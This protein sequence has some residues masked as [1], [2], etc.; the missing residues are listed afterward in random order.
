M[1]NNPVNRENGINS[2]FIY[3]G[4]MMF[5]TED[6][7]AVI[8][9]IHKTAVNPNQIS[10][11]F[12]NELANKMG[13]DLTSEQVVYISDNCQAYKTLERIFNQI[14]IKVMTKTEQ[15]NKIIADSLQTQLDRADQMWK[16]GQ[17]PAYIV[18]WLQGVIKATIV[19]LTPDIRLTR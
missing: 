1:K 19:E 6:M 11:N 3:K 15:L 10:P 2:S 4:K 13:R 5:L 18:G 12:V 17:S 7:R 9:K 16:E 14:K 8:I